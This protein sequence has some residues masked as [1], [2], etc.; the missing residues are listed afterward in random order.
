M[1]SERASSTL[2]SGPGGRL[3]NR[4]VEQF[5]HLLHGVVRQVHHSLHPLSSVLV[6]R[7]VLLEPCS[8]H[9]I[10]SFFI[11]RGVVVAVLLVDDSAGHFSL[12]LGSCP[13]R[14]DILRSVV[15]VTVLGPGHQLVPR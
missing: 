15:T 3:L 14:R 1:L 12:L 11:L 9:S 7:C 6:N 8:L 10:L 5:V 4:F 2:V 13:C